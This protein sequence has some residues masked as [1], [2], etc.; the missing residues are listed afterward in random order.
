MDINLGLNYG[1][2]GNC[3]TNNQVAWKPY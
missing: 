3:M 1:L 2:C